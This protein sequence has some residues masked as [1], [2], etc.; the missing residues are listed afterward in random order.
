MNGNGTGSG[1]GNSGGSGFRPD[2]LVKIQGRDFVV[3][4]GRLRVVHSASTKV[5]ITT[6]IVDFT[7]E[8]HAVVRAR[9]STQAGEFT[10]TGV[11][12]AA[13]DPKL[14]ESLLELAETRAIARALRFAGI[15]VECCG[16]EELGAGPVLEADPP[17]QDLRPVPGRTNGAPSNGGGHRGTPCTSAQRR[18]LQSLARQLGQD[19]DDVVVKVFPDTNADHLTLGQA[20][21]L[22]DKMKAKASNGNGAG[23]GR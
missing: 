11:A 17:R 23:T 15:G 21:A 12:T 8:A 5:S 2:E 13:R 7:L 14:V 6:D 9:V 1:N 19:L 18:A 10:G 4:G 22:I 16:F 20:S 3:I